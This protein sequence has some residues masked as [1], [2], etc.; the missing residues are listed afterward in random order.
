MVQKDKNS[1][2][3]EVMYAYMD[4]ILSKN[5]R[6]NEVNISEYHSWALNLTI[7]NADNRAILTNIMAVDFNVRFQNY[8]NTQQFI[9]LVESSEASIVKALHVA[10]SKQNKFEI[11]SGLEKIGSDY[12]QSLAFLIERYE[13]ISKHGEV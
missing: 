11:I 10:Y 13:E 1:E 8:T 12:S 4:V 3:K 5:G 7:E 9:S 6:P 2:L